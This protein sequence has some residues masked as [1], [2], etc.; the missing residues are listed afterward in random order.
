MLGDLEGNTSPLTQETY[1]V[2]VKWLDG[3]HF[4]YTRQKAVYLGTIDK[5]DI[6][7]AKLAEN[8]TYGIFNVFF[9]R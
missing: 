5:H 3:T 2:L 1:M 8:D 6:L 4:L 9:S 7:V